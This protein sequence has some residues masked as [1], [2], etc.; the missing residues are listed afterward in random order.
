MELQTVP[1]RTQETWDWEAGQ[2]RT[3][4]TERDRGGD[5]DLNTQGLLID[6]PQVNTETRQE[7]DKGRKWKAKHDTQGENFKIKMGITEPQTD[8][9]SQYN[10]I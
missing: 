4:W 6:E 1:R 8:T 9:I 3:E 10:I 7:K 2:N 5:K